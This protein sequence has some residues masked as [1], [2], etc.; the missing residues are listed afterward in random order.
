[1]DMVAVRPDLQ[2]RDLGAVADVK[3]D[4]PQTRRRPA[5]GPPQDRR[6]TAAGP[7]QDRRRTASV[8]T[9]RRYFV[10]QTAWYSKAETL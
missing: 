7:P 5:A 10:G 2:E 3:A 6:R 4:P 8:M 9:A 1:M